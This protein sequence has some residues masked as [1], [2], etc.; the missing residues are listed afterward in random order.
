LKSKH[1][2]NYT[3]L[4]GKYIHIKMMQPDTPM[5]NQVT[6]YINQ[7]DSTTG[8]ENRIKIY[9]ELFDYLVMN[10]DS[11]DTREYSRISDILMGKLTNFKQN[12]PN[13]LNAD[14]YLETLFPGDMPSG[15]VD[16]TV[17]TASNPTTIPTPTP[18]STSTTKILFCKTVQLY[19][20]ECENARGKK[21]RAA[22]C[23]KVFDYIVENKDLINRDT[24]FVN[25]K[26][27]LFDKLLKFKNEELFDSNK[28]IEILFPETFKYMKKLDE[29]YEKK[30]LEMRESFESNK[31]DVDKIIEDKI[32]EDK[33]V[34]DKIENKVENKVV[35]NFIFEDYKI[36]NKVVEN[37]IFEDYKINTTT[38]F[39][40]VKG[41][42]L[43]EKI[44]DTL[45]T[46]QYPTSNSSVILSML[47]ANK[48]I[49][50]IKSDTTYPNGPFLIKINDTSYELY[51]KLTETVVSKG[52]LYN[53]TS[54]NIVIN[55][56]GRYVY[57]L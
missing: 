9:K 49:E 3:Y 6:R 20:D 41:N 40:D 13:A 55:K 17:S 15:K 38:K 47:N 14:Y 32:I 48:T 27:V 52:Y 8:R 42:N 39:I 36:E 11:W 34:E 1:Y 28:Y 24:S 30:I 31:V 50:Q 4:K 57:A 37:F 19:L 23:T 53:S 33:I 16:G 22:I 18:T 12:M 35:E 51:E 26:P 21:S 25:F 46:V 5:W 2:E 54:S 10:K 44:I 43:I 29:Y 56:L 7:I 45:V